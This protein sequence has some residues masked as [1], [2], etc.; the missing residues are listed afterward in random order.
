MLTSLF[1]RTSPVSVSEIKVNKYTYK[2]RLFPIFAPY[3]KYAI[4]GG[5]NFMAG[6]IMGNTLRNN[7]AVINGTPNYYH[8]RAV[9]VRSAEIIGQFS[10]TMTGTKIPS[11]KTV[12]PQQQQQQQLVK[13]I[14]SYF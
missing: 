2:L 1:N 3:G 9:T 7:N 11:V 14:H 12:N 6:A 8:N 10:K 5:Y 4:V 13:V